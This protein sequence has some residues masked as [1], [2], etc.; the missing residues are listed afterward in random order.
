MYIVE[1]VPNVPIF[2]NKNIMIGGK[3]IFKKHGLKKKKIC[4]L[5]D[6]LDFRGNFYTY[7]EFITI[8]DVKTNFLEYHGVIAAVKHWLQRA[9]FP[10]NFFKLQAP[11]IPIS[12]VKLIK[13]KKGSKEFHLK[14]VV[15]KVRRHPLF[16]SYI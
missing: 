9:D 5:Y 8:C 12:V 10:F 3:H 13:N 15:P 2:Y 7:N 1:S 6:L 4:L 16:S 14:R 11:T